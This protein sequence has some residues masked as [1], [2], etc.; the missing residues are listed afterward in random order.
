MYGYRVKNKESGERGFI[1]CSSVKFSTTGDAQVIVIYP[2][3]LAVTAEWLTSL[4]MER[5][6]ELTD[7][8]TEEKSG[9][10][11]YTF[12][13]DDPDDTTH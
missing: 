11:L 12:D 10:Q 6:D 7:T 4:E 13:R 5:Y 9:F 3:T 1:A 2:D 8:D